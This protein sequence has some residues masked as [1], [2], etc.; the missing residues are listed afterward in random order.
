[1]SLSKQSTSSGAATSGGH[2]Y[3]VLCSQAWKIVF[4][5]YSFFKMYVSEDE[6]SRLKFAK[7][8]GLTTGACGVHKSSVFMDLQGCKEI[9]VLKEIQF[10]CH[11]ETD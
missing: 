1:M 5:V 9:L 7:C 6:Q 2:S 4:R 11:S 8:Q 3:E 10:L